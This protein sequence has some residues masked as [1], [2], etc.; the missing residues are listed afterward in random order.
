MLSSQRDARAGSEYPR[1][2]APWLQ[3]DYFRRPRSLRRVRTR[4]SWVALIVCAVAVT[5]LALAPRGQTL[6]EAA[7]VSAPHAMINDDCNAC[8][9]V[10]FGTGRRLVAFTDAVHSV[11]DAACLRC[12][13]GAGHHESRAGMEHCASCHRE[14]RGPAGLARVDDARCTGCHAD[15]KAVVRRL[16]E[17]PASDPVFRDVAAFLGGSKPHPQFAERT[18]PGTIRFNHAAH[19]DARGVLMPGTQNRERLEC[20]GCHQVGPDRR[21]MQ[22]I[23]YEQHCGR[24]HPLT[25]DVGNA[26]DGPELVAAAKRFREQPVPHPNRNESAE[27]VVAVV[28][29]RYLA[30]ARQFP[31]VHSSP[32]GSVPVPVAPGRRRR[33]AALPIRGEAEW[34]DRQVKE[35]SRV[36]FEGAGGCRYCHREAIPAQPAARRL[37]RYAPSQIK[38]RWFEHGIFDH[39]GHRS[40]DCQQCHAGATASRKTSDV[41]LPTI[42]TCQKCHNGTA[43]SARTDCVECHEYHDAT[44]SRRPAAD[45]TIEAYLKGRARP[46][47]ERGR[48]PGVD[49]GSP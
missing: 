16:G 28:R 15:L 37:P 5:A 21:T 42:E 6:F 12:H 40:L 45:L 41:L 25:I 24:C 32:A 43:R 33:E 9:S 7:P 18:D 1:S 26:P 14:H 20:A 17:A 31:T 10:S 47:A 29:D 2:L 44:R 3:L 8:H 30:F 4:A 22:P 35:A 38:S 48:S 27:T 46:P 34:A 11:S 49:Q 13:N 36:M 23:R 39:D 19:L